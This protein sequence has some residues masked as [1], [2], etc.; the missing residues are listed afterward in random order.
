M[1]SKTLLLQNR[2]MYIREKY[3]QSNFCPWYD[4]NDKNFKILKTIRISVGKL[5]LSLQISSKM[6]NKGEISHSSGL[7]TISVTSLGDFYVF[8]GH[9]LR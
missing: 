2:R 3:F 5:H 7:Y 1:F 9:N 8:L 6:H 4:Q